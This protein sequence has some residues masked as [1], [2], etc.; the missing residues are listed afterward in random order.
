M[1][2][3][4][5]RL[6]GAGRNVGD[7]ELALRLDR[8]LN[9]ISQGLCFFD[10]RHRLIICNSRYIEMYG[11]PA[12]RVRPGISLRE[13]VDL[14]FAAG[15]GPAM[16]KEDYL[17][18]RDSIAIS[19]VATDT[20]VTLLNGSIISVRHRPMPDGGWVAT[21]ED[22]T[23]LKKREDSFRLL[24]HS[25]PVPMWVIDLSTLRFL[26]VNNAAVSH[27]G[28]A[29]GDFLNMTA[30][31]LRFAEDAQA[32]RRQVLTGD[33]TQGARTWRHR[34]ANGEA[35]L[36]SVYAEDLDYEGRPARLCAAVDV[37]ERKR[38]EEKLFEQKLH[39]DTAID[40][41]SQG[42]VMFDA[43]GR[44][45]LFNRRY[46]EMYNLSSDVVQPGCTLRELIAYRQQ[47]GSFSGDPDAYSQG[48]IEGIGNGQT[49]TRSIEL[50]DGRLIQIV[51]KPMEGG[52]WV[53][54]HDDVTEAKRAQE[55]IERESNEHRRL[56]E[57]SQ[58][59]ILVTDRRGDV[60]RV[61]PIVEDI[62]G[63]RPDELIGRSA[64][65]V[66]YPDDLEETRTAMRLARRGQSTRNC[67]TRYHHKD[68]RVVTLAWSGVWSEPE[69]I[70]FFTCRDVT[71]R[72][73][74]DERLRQLAHYDQ[75]TGLP[76]RESL[77][78]D[79]SELIYASAEPDGRQTS[80][81]MFDLDGFKD[82]N[83]TLGHSTGD[84]L[85]L[86]AARRMS[87]LASQKARFYRLGGDEF[88]LILADCGDPRDAGELVGSVIKSLGRGFDVNG[89]PIFVGASAGIAIAPAHGLS[90]DEL[91]SNA[92][93]ALYDAKAA[94]GR[95][96]RL[97]MPVLRAKAELR[98]E[99]DTEL[100]RACD[101]QEFV[102]YFQPQIRM[103][104]GAVT[105]AEALLRW[106]HPHRGI[107]G[108]GAFIDTLAESAV[109][110]EVGTWI[111]ET[112]C[113]TAASLR[114]KGHDIRMGVNMF[115][116]QF[117][118]ERL[119]ADIE[120]ALSKTGLPPEALEIEITENIA[121]GHDE[122]L[123]AP[124]RALRDR[125]VQLAFDDFGT[126]YASLSFLTRYPLTR[127][128]IDQSFVRKIADRPAREDTAIVRS[129]IMMAH[130]LGMDVIAE[131]V[132][133]A[134]QAAFLHAE[135][136]DEVQGFLYAKPLPADEFEEYLVA[137]RIRAAASAR[138]DRS[139]EATG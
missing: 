52:G 88:V 28:Y 58:D 134:A 108:P 45:L 3:L 49:V 60:I 7:E 56:F 67:E 77:W 23:E 78:N 16:S 10:G 48:I 127:L 115:P 129:I 104:D 37:T 99:L 27:Y 17:T 43:K 46:L 4:L 39:I 73:M 13:I 47:A 70:Y 116:A 35:I 24:F 72:K 90:V 12:A 109:V 2:P 126:G 18:W 98:R 26:D 130:N 87:D 74:V 50:P 118:A 94:G 83:D 51:N 113:R 1:F 5:K 69:Q 114:A 36:V 61:S 100:R 97:F 76:N 105:G 11:L 40:N 68:G 124:L 112:A 41:M 122:A 131:G 34:K 139:L 92:D 53:V 85:L 33:K 120:S 29:R 111:L 121:L 14:R 119:Q 84:R 64:A 79:L 128:K 21:H 80:I 63:Y 6:R 101:Q 44:T 19:D 82:V 65:H 22:I 81:A 30:A 9:N 102:L 138:K 106:R 103:S 117:Q 107:L 136:C 31:D 54:T 75:L 55:R 135:R 62:L 125:G 133:T 89:H 42:L 59:M 32:F 96:Y 95:C 15:T 66:I 71:Q 86:E 137:A 8:A 132:E 93:L 20:V 57:L 38:S 91:L 123:L 25:N 110:L